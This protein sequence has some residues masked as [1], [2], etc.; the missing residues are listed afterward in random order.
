MSQPASLVPHRGTAAHQLLSALVNSDEWRP[1]TQDP[2]LWWSTDTPGIREAKRYCGTCPIIDQCREYALAAGETS[3]VWG[4][5][6][7]GERWRARRR[8][9]FR[10]AARRRKAEREAAGTL[11][12]EAAA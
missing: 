1:C 9:Y 12:P 3:G 8:E 7:A 4:G 6:D 5:M 10:E 2:E 11:E